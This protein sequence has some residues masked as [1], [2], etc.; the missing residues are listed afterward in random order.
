MH[1]VG[2][3]YVTEIDARYSI[4]HSIVRNP[5]FE[6]VHLRLIAGEISECKYT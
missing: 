5:L 2:T 3:N 4:A 6:L 1:G